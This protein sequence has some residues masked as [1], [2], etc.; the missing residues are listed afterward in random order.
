MHMNADR[1]IELVSEEER[2]LTASS[3]P[4]PTVTIRTRLDF[5]TPPDK[6]PRVAHAEVVV[7]WSSS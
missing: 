5:M 6:T 3:C 7:V 1:M 2:K 4:M